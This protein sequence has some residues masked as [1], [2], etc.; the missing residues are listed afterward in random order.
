MKVKKEECSEDSLELYY[1]INRIAA[2]NEY[3][4]KNS[5]G[6]D[7]YEMALV[8]EPYYEEKE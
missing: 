3:M 5:S 2:V 1:Y 7:V 6:D 4:E 8:Q